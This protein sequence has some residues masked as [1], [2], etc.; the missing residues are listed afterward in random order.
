MKNKKTVNRGCS[1]KE[2]CFCCI[3]LRLYDPFTDY[4][5]EK[6]VTAIYNYSSQFERYKSTNNKNNIQIF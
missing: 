1:N 3:V 5:V 2:L 4:I 6:Y